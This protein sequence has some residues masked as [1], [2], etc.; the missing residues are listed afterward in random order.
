MNVSACTSLLRKQK[1]SPGEEHILAGAG[2]KNAKA[3]EAR[4]GIM[5]LPYAVIGNRMK[6]H[7]NKRRDST[8]RVQL[9]G[10]IDV[11]C[12]IRAQTEIK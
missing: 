1:G 6:N 7:A 3:D 10:V 2:I 12:M 4:A 9:I 11:F 5:P 8:W